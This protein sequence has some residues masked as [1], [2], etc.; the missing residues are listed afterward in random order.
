M[1]RLFDLSLHHLRGSLPKEVV[2]TSERIALDISKS[3]NPYYIIPDLLN[4]RD[5]EVRNKI[6]GCIISNTSHIYQEKAKRPFV[7]EGQTKIINYSEISQAI[8]DK[9][10]PEVAKIL[11][12][13][14]KL[15]KQ[16]DIEVVGKLLPLLKKYISN[17]I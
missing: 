9:A 3:I 11:D 1:E 7:I 6:K 16:N 17:P 10:K 12:K 13:H 8:L 14:K 4:N 2:G 5:E 15:K